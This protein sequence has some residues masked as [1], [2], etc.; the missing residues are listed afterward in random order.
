M[1]D[2]VDAENAAIMRHYA[3]HR[4][5]AATSSYELTIKHRDGHE[6]NVLVSDT[7]LFD[8]AQQSIGAVVVV[9]DI[10]LQKQAGKKPFSRH[11]KKKRCWAS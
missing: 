6:I 3:E 7:P 9:T 4:R 8:T 10:T 5:H 2:Y 11:S 1:F